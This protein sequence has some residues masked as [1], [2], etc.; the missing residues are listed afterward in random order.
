[1]NVAQFYHA[2]AD[3]AWQAPLS[4]HIQVTEA[5]GFGAPLNTGVIGTPANRERL[6]SWLRDRLPGRWHPVAE[7][8]HGFEEVTLMAVRDW[9]LRNDGCVLY[10]HDKGAMNNS[11]FEA[12]WRRRVTGELAGRW[13]H[14]VSLLERSDAVGCHWLHPAQDWPRPWPL[15]GN[16]I[17]VTHPH[18]SGN[19]WW[20]TAEYL[21]TLPEW[22]FQVPH[23]EG[24]C[25]P[26]SVP[27]ARGETTGRW[28]AELWIGAG[29]PQVCDLYPG[30]PGEY[31]R[32][33]RRSG[34]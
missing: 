32:V 8:D 10:C 13:Q 7:A 2:W 15:D 16:R 11:G 22:P 23:S 29:N 6:Y 14:C 3:G 20:A 24:C 18:F 19:F 27:Q 25:T 28:L 26:D 34:G 12:E 21:R 17:R 5:A 30:M 9:A 4:E 31:V 1:V 33:Q